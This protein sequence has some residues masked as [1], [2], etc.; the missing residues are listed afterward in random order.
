MIVAMTIILPWLKNNKQEDEEENKKYSNSELSL[1]FVVK[2]VEKGAN[3][4]TYDCAFTY[5]VRDD[6]NAFNLLAN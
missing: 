4:L 3:H 2:F 1:S 6:G 5:C